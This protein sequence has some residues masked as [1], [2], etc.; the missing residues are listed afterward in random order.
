M[1]ALA[2]AEAY[3]QL[4]SR[5]YDKYAGILERV[6]Q[7]L[8]NNLRVMLA[9][10][11]KFSEDGFSDGYMFAGGLGVLGNVV[12]V[13]GEDAIERFRDVH[14]IDVLVRGITLYPEVGAAFDVI[15][16]YGRSYQ[17]PNKRFIRGMC[18][19]LDGSLMEA[20]ADVFVPFSKGKRVEDSSTRIW[21]VMGAYIHEGHWEEFDSRRAVEAQRN[22]T[23]ANF[24]GL[25]VGCVHP[26]S[27]LEMKLNVVCSHGNPREK[28]CNDVMNLV[29]VLEK[30]GFPPAY[31]REWI[32][33]ARRACFKNLLT[34]LDY[35]PIVPFS[36]SYKG[37]LLK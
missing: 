32:S 26:L 5:A 8:A 23:K 30:K 12:G 3:M 31:V 25:S 14:D 18:E 7:G 6:P 34:N 10:S 33:P 29:G 24:F 4:A 16:D 19:A 11:Y 13:A 15:E 1:G 9:I 28:D 35:A 22:M 36:R 21:R 20:E 17:I 37:E 27:L 2:D